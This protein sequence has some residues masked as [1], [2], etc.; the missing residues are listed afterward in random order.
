MRYIK[1]LSGAWHV[2]SHHEGNIRPQL[3]IV[4]SCAPKVLLPYSYSVWHV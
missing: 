3:R 1:M 2:S 4:V